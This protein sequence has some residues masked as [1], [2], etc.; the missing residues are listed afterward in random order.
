MSIQITVNVRDTHTR[1]AGGEARA[2]IWRDGLVRA[3]VLK[4]GAVSTGTAGVAGAS[5]A[6]IH[7]GIKD[8]RH[9]YLD[10]EVVTD[11]GPDPLVQ[12]HLSAGV[13]LCEGQPVP[14]HARRSTV[15]RQSSIADTP[16]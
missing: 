12:D 16:G 5:G 10:T 15:R 9:Q 4:D 3:A 14:T 1:R 11:C 2:M 13:R 8:G 6:E 7:R